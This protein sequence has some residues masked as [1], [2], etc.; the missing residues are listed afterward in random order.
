MK[1]R[2]MDDDANLLDRRCPWARSDHQ[3]A[4]G[5]GKRDLGPGDNT[6]NFFEGQA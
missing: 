1:V 5:D 4:L 6:M 2:F 3:P